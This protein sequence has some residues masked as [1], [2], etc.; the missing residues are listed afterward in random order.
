MC[1]STSALGRG[2]PTGGGGVDGGSFYAPRSRGWQRGGDGGM[3]ENR[4]VYVQFV[5]YAIRRRLN[6][7]RRSATRTRTHRRTLYFVRVCVCTHGGRRRRARCDRRETKCREKRIRR[8][9]TT[10]AATATACVE[11]RREI[12]KGHEQRVS[13]CGVRADRCSV[14]GRSRAKKTHAH[15]GGQK[16]CYACTD[17]A[18]NYCAPRRTTYAHRANVVTCAGGLTRHAIGHDVVLTGSSGDRSDRSASSV[19]RAHK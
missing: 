10:A 15:D 1:A 16:S 13:A 3:S 2:G 19:A 4:V 17:G 12:G 18:H 9:A 5:T 6:N 8:S 14:Y 7:A 11:R